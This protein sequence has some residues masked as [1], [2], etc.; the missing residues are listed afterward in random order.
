MS[1]GPS[2][3]A[4]LTP[5]LSK[6]LR[7]RHVGMISIGGIIGWLF[8]WLSWATIA[9]MLSVLGAM[10]TTRAPASQL[11]ASL[12]CVAVVAFAYGVARTRRPVT[13]VNA[14]GVLIR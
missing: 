12:V 13:P 10:A 4:K 9:A 11:Y 3:D 5:E 6:S 1:R 14:R 8:P 2:A 7:S